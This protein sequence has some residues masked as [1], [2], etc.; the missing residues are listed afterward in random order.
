MEIWET[1][2]WRRSWCSGRERE[3]AF[4]EGKTMRWVHSLIAASNCAC[5]V[6]CSRKRMISTY[7]R[8]DVR[9]LCRK[10][11]RKLFVVGDQVGNIDITVVL[12]DKDVLS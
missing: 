3:L 6:N 10:L 9:W 12:F 8:Y 7:E 4:W 11:V 2:E 1:E 5:S